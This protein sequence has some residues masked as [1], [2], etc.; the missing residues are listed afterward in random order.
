MLENEMIIDSNSPLRWIPANTNRKRMLFY[1]GIRYSVEMADLA[2][3]RLHKTLS[4][5]EPSPTSPKS[6]SRDF[7]SAIL[8][9]WSIVDLIHR[10]RGLLEQTPGIKQNSPALALFM[11]KTVEVEKLRN[12]VQHLNQ[13]IHKIA[14]LNLPVWGALSWE[15][16]FDPELKS[17]WTCTLV[18]GTFF[19]RIDPIILPFGRKFY[20][21]VDLITLQ[22][23]DCS[24]CLSDVMRSVEKLVRSLEEYLREQF[25]DL[26]SAGRDALLCGKFV[27][28]EPESG[29]RGG[30]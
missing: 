14:N 23:S 11:W 29:G 19:E 2:H 20:P 12:S 27:F 15:T 30:A 21:P 16:R 4:E 26:P 17:M 7:A 22:A 28:R 6:N 18:A 25:K 1:D 8:D 10:L 13:Q 24:V 9:A 5:I 3:N